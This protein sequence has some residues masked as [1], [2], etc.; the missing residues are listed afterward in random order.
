M[1]HRRAASAALTNDERLRLILALRMLVIAWTADP[2]APWGVLVAAAVENGAQYEPP[3]TQA[4]VQRLRGYVEELFD[5][6]GAAR[7]AQQRQRARQTG[8]RHRPGRPAVG[9]PTDK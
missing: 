2:R 9:P 4:E 1:T 5:P 8:P 3:I 7:R 6:R